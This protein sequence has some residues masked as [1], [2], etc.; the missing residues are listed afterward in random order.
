V[1]WGDDGNGQVSN[2]PTDD[3]FIQVACGGG[4]MIALKSDG[5]LVSWGSDGYSLVSDTPTDNDFVQVA[6][7]AYHSLALKSDG[8]LVSWGYDNYNVITNTPTSSGFWQFIIFQLYSLFNDNGTLYTIDDNSL[9]DTGLSEPLTL[10]DFETHGVK[11]KDLTESDWDLL[12]DQFEI[13]TWTDGITDETTQ[14]ILVDLTV[15]E[16]KP[17]NWLPQPVAISTWTDSTDPLEL[18]MTYNAYSKITYQVST[19]NETWWGFNSTTGQFEE[20]YEM[21]QSE[22]EGI[23]ETQFRNWVGDSIYKFDFYYKINLE[24]D[25]PDNLP[26]VSSFETT[27]KPNQGPVINNFNITPD[28]IHNNH[29]EVTGELV[30]LEG[31]TI[32][33]RVLISKVNDITTET[34][35]FI[36]TASGYTTP[37]GTIS[38]SSEYN[39]NYPAW[40]AFN[41][42]NTDTYDAWITSSGTVSG[43]LQIQLDTPQKMTKYSVTSRGVGTIAAPKDWT[44]EGSD[45]G[46]NWDVLD[47]ISDETGWSAGER[48]EYTIDNPS[49]YTY[50]RINISG[51]DGSSYTAIDELEIFKSERFFTEVDPWTTKDNYSSFFRAY[52]KSYFEE[53]TNQIKVEVRDQRSELGSE[54]TGNI[55][56]TNTAP[57]INYSYNEFNVHGEIGDVDSDNIRYRV[58]IN[59]TPIME[60]TDWMETPAGFRAEWTS[61]DVRLGEMNA[62]TIE[63]EDEFNEITTES[64]DIMGKYNGLLF[65][66]EEGNY[67]MSDQGVEL[68]KLELPQIIAGQNSDPKRVKLLNQTGSALESVKISALKG[69]LPDTANVYIDLDG[70]SFT[71]KTL[72]ELNEVM[73]HGDERDFYVAVHTEMGKGKIGANFHVKTEGTIM[74]S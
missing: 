46:V 26:S 29:V 24:S 43:W 28:E 71:P 44:F 74:V 1:S 39:A 50:Y 62:V 66:D 18:E 9:V 47:T 2:T 53:G 19:D 59:G 61:D 15:E 6:C 27:F 33:Y 38:A 49:E 73:N 54:Y 23:T 11:L 16:N 32:D 10:S 68:K 8:T 72:I 57:N 52:D 7:G 69:D 20:N 22:L 55:V 45:D 64:F 13:I 56:L 21:S 14:E 25:N 35:D 58:K 42:S 63:A 4:H 60:W 41:D 65:L 51:N 34:N 17:I 5:T 31:D 37:E 36:S 67:Y 70:S 40:K 3:N 30:D 12:P 48:R